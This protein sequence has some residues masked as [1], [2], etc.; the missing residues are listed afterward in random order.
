MI[1]YMVFGAV[2]FIAALSFESIFG[3]VAVANNGLFSFHDYESPEMTGLE[4]LEL[5]SDV[6]KLVS[7]LFIHV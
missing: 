5:S 4:L 6:E 3:D 1:V 7:I 2:G